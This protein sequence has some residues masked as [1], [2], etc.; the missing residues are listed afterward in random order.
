MYFPDA[1]KKCISESFRK[2]ETQLN[3]NKDFMQWYK[4]SDP[5]YNTAF[6]LH[7]KLKDEKEYKR[8]FCYA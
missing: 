3:H 4:D 2:M 6:D 5:D 8:D 1:E 7:L